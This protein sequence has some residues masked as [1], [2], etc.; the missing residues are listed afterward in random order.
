[1]FSTV[2]VKCWEN[3]HCIWGTTKESAGSKQ[4]ER[5]SSSLLFCNYYFCVPGL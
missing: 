2:I 5:N 4:Q 1:M 3:L